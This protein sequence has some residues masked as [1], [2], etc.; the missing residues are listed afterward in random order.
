MNVNHKLK[1]I[2]YI[3]DSLIS[4]YKTRNPFE[5]AHKMNIN[6]SLL[7]FDNDLLAFSSKNSNYDNGTIYINKHVGNYAAKILCA[8]EIG[9]MIM[10]KSETNL[11]DK[12][13]EP[14]KEF[15]ANYFTVCLVDTLAQTIPSKA[16]VSVEAFNDHIDKRI[17][18]IA[19]S[20][21][22]SG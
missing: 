3:V 20:F 5:L 8:H 13:I 9:H 2:E 16:L 7:D 17:R 22:T 1:K 12:G 18:Y 14:I 4:E 19:H 21:K 11:F 6:I 10:H 15:E